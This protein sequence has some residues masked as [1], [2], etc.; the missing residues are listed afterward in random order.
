ML[1]QQLFFILLLTEQIKYLTLC[2]VEQKVQRKSTGSGKSGVP[3]DTSKL[4][5]G[6]VKH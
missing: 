6:A 3:K 4:N 2:I 1:L 5:F